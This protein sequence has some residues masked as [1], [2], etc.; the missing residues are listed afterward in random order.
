[1]AFNFPIGHTSENIPIP[2]G[3]EAVL[4]VDENSTL[5]LN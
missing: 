3:M 4:T 1:V 2:I 5:Q